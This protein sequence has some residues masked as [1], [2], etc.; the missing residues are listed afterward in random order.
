MFNLHWSKGTKSY[1]SFHGAK[2]M[3]NSIQF[4]SVQFQ[5]TC[6]CTIRWDIHILGMQV[7]KKTNVVFK[8]TRKL[9]FVLG[10]ANGTNVYG[11]LR[12][13]HSIL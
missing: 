11:Y 7:N 5:C 3:Y 13:K 10:E 2:Q 4:N 9:M 8:S 12:L 1:I 6:T